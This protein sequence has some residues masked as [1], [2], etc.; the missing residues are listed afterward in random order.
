MLPT[1]PPSLNSQKSDLDI[2]LAISLS[3]TRSSPPEPSFIWER[4]VASKSRGLAMTLGRLLDGEQSGGKVS[5]DL[6]P[7]DSVESVQVEVVST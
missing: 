7:C 3:I 5:G 4:R 6:L 2:N 1:F